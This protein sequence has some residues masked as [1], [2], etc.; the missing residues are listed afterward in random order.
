MNNREAEYRVPTEVALQSLGN[1]L[2]RVFRFDNASQS[3]T[4]F[5]PRHAFLDV[6]SLR[7]MS[8]G[9]MFWIFVREGQVVEL[10]QHSGVLFAGWNLILY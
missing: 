8:N 4:F 7:T 3:W 2:I 10:G 5:D 1:N 6:N 9:E